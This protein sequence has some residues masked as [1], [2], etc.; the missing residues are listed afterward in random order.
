MLPLLKGCKRGGQR[1][2]VN[3]A[4]LRAIA[5][6]WL[7]RGIGESRLES[8]V[9]GG[10][11]DRRPSDCTIYTLYADRLANTKSGRTERVESR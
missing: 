6:I 2:L 4:R 7:R 9:M 5:D 8:L 11:E 1:Q 10:K 3:S